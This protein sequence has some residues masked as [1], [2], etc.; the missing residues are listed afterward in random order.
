MEEKMNYEKTTWQNGDIITAEK[1]N[2]IENGL[3]SANVNFITLTDSG[4][5]TI[6]PNLPPDYFLN[7]V[8]INED[9][10]FNNKFPTLS[11][12]EKVEAQDWQSDGYKQYGLLCG[13]GYYLYEISTGIISISE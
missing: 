12:V 1:L 2:N 8:F 10:D 6:A 4:Q 3:T 5:A 9:H 7:V 11:R 13:G